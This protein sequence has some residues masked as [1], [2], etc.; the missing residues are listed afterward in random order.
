MREEP[1]LGDHAAHLQQRRRSGGFTAVDHKVTD[2][3]SLRGRI[4]VER[5]DFGSS[6]RALFNRRDNFPHEVTPEPGGANCNQG[7]YNRDKH[8]Y[9]NAD[10]GIPDDSPAT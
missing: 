1:E 10:P 6:A 4:E 7:G 3:D 5:S 9:G 2:G 8:Q